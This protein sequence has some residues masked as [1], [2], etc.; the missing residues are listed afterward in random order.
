[1]GIFTFSPVAQSC[2]TLCDPWTAEHQA[3][4]SITKSQ[5][6]L[7]LMSIKPVIPSNHLILS[8]PIPAFNLS[9]HQGFC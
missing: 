1:M 2:L 4:L 5:S 3:S 7:K 6:L 9:Q 8:S